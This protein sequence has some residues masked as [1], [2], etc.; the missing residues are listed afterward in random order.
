MLKSDLFPRKKEQINSYSNALKM[1]LLIIVFFLYLFIWTGL[2]A[3]N[4][5]EEF[6]YKI[7]TEIYLPHLE[8][9]SESIL[10]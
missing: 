3:E 7:L 9:F 2:S 6:G 8:Q 1:L 4:F 5:Q 10:L